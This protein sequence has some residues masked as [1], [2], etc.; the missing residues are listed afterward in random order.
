VTLLTTLALDSISRLG[1]ERSSV[2]LAGQ[3][4]KLVS[5][6][7][8]QHDN[9]LVAEATASEIAPDSPRAQ[10]GCGISARGVG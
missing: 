2:A 7:A 6:G 9:L 1:P 5:K 8:L 3:R 10:T 4:T